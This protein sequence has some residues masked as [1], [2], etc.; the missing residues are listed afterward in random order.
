MRKTKDGSPRPARCDGR[1]SAGGK[2]NFRVGQCV[3][4]T[5]MGNALPVDVQ[6]VLSEWVNARMILEVQV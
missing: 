2:R 4:L 3:I 1:E 5:Q 6:Y